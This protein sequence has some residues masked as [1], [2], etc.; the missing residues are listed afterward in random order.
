M[1]RQAIVK[2]VVEIHDGMRLIKETKSDR[3]Q[4]LIR[5]TTKNAI[6]KLAAEKGISFNELVHQILDD[7][8]DCHT[9]HI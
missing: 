6:L 7:Y 2:S 1:A 9:A 5:P 4:L 3:A 8:V